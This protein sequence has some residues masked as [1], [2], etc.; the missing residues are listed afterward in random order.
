MYEGKQKIEKRV[1]SL[2]IRRWVVKVFVSAVDCGY[3]LNMI[4][5][6]ALKI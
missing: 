4:S 3:L 6:A 1:W 2:R 5:V